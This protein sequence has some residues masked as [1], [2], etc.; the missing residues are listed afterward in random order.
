MGDLINKFKQKLTDDAAIY[1]A[2]RLG[3]EIPAKTIRLEVSEQFQI[4]ISI[5]RILNLTSTKRWGTVY[6]AAHESYL[7]QINDL[8]GIA[9]AAQRT[10]L[11]AGDKL[12]D[13]LL[14][15]FTKIEKH[16]DEADKYRQ[17]VIQLLAEL[18]TFLKNCKDK[19]LIKDAR[20]TLS[21]LSFCDKKSNDLKLMRELRDT[22]DM[23]LKV[24]KMGKEETSAKMKSPA[25]SGFKKFMASIKK[26]SLTT[27]IPNGEQKV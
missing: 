3:C 24:L 17:T 12:Q 10:R 9:L 4:D 6:D 19:W 14:K 1:I 18:P 8:T 5:A 7:T 26:P 20:D 22:M 16:V 13:R 11:K 2:Q 21:S 25:E 15:M 23:Y 27:G